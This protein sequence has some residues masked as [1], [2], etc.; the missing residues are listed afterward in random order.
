MVFNISWCFYISFKFK[1]K[2]KKKKK[3]KPFRGVLR[4][5]CSEN[6]QLIYRRNCKKMKF[7]IKDFFS[8]YDQIRSTLRIWSHLQKKSL[9]EN[10]IFHAVK[11]P[12]RKCDLN[13]VTKQLWNRTSVW[14]FSCKF[15]AYFRTPFPLLLFKKRLN[16]FHRQR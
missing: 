8:K 2:K 12:M 16:L 1:K 6:M 9:M 4:K 11:K 14:V 13:K 3:N 5:G 15:G 10:F 7:P